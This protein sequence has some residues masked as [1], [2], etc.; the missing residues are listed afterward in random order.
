[1]SR[2]G[3]ML[4]VVTII[5]LF[6]MVYKYI[7][8]INA[9]DSA[10]QAAESLASAM[11]NAYAGPVGSKYYYT[12]PRRISGLQ[13][14]LSIVD[15]AKTGILINVF[16]TRCG[17]SP[18]GAP[19]KVV[20]ANFSREIKNESDENVTLLLENLDGRLLIGRKSNCAG[21]LQVERIQYNAPGYDC[22]NTE[23]E[24]VIL[25][26]SCD[27]PFDL[28]GW[29]LSDLGHIHAYN[30]MEY[31]LAP[32]SHV[33]LHT[34]CGEDSSTDLYWCNHGPGCNAV[35]NND[36]DTLYLTD[37]MNQTRI[38]YSY[39]PGDE[40]NQTCIEYTY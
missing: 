38:E 13:Y 24:Y 12:L 7:N 33:Y 36:G 15:G 40:V 37:G 16:G 4:A 31:V 11:A 30:F 28:S 39:H 18:G 34:S 35:W 17:S 8:C 21:C 6:Y 29:Q 20:L 19:V 27:T 26:N 14:N 25:N 2:L 5:L 10:N 1:M 3:I 23:E 32:D 22:N 9:S